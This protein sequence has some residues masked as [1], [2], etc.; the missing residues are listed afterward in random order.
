MINIE[1]MKWTVDGKI[2]SQAIL[3]INDVYDRYI[4]ASA[5]NAAWRRSTSPILLHALTVRQAM[6]R[7][8]RVENI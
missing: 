8:L 6:L 7:E 4:F 5:A 3:R 2:R 1:S